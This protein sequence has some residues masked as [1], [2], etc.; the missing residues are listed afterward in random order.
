MDDTIAKNSQ[1]PR[2]PSA[3]E[4]A[5]TK[6]AELVAGSYDRRQVRLPLRLFGFGCF[7]LVT[8]EL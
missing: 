7:N 2:V 1:D 6:R 3:E 4:G 5:T 8:W